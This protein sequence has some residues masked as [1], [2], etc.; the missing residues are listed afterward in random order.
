[1]RNKIAKIYIETP[2]KPKDD[3]DAKQTKAKPNKT[4]QKQNKNIYK[5]HDNGMNI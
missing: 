1:L 5:K 3:V 2:T 4:K